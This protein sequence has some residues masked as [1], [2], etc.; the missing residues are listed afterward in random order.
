MRTSIAK[1]SY[2]FVIF[3]VGMGGSGTLSPPLDPH[4]EKS[5]TNKYVCIRTHL[6]NEILKPMPHRAYQEEDKL[7]HVCIN[8]ASILLQISAHK[9]NA[10]R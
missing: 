5:K 9:Q 10:I 4:M 3:Q 7:T 1:K 2:I 6:F 8:P